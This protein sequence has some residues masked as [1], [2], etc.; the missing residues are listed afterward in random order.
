MVVAKKSGEN[1][2]A[3]FEI[4]KNC[5]VIKTIHV[6]KSFHGNPMADAFFAT[7]A[8]WNADETKFVYVAEVMESFWAYHCCVC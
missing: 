8:G 1:D 2:G 4:W 7:K 3:C 6:P 5:R